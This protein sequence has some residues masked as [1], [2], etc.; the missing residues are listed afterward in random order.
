M[1][2]GTAVADVY[3]AVGTEM[4][5]RLQFI[6]RRDFAVARRNT[7]DGIDLSGRVAALC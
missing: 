6:E 2:V 7:N 5:S 1:D 3:D 4:K